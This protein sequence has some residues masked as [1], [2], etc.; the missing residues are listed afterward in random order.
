MPDM[1]KREANELKD[2]LGVE[3]ETVKKAFAEVFSEALPYLNNPSLGTET[4]RLLAK[5]LYFGFKVG[6]LISLRDERLRIL[7]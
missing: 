7:F 2:K 1:T 5:N 4:D 6:F 3:T